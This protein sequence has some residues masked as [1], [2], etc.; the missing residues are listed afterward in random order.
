M[1]KFFASAF[2]LSATLALVAGLVFA[3]VGTASAPAGVS[4][5]I[6]EVDVALQID[7]YTYSPLLPG[8]SVKTAN[9][10][11]YNATGIPVYITGGSISGI[12]V[13]SN[14]GCEPFI[15]G[16]VTVTDNNWINNNSYG[17]GWD[18]YL[19]LTSN[20]HQDCQTLGVNYTINVDV[21]T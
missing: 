17:G 3:W 19:A 8:I 18:S 11:V 21:T 4:S 20:T 5:V 2:A 10:R 12:D 9:G 16:S 14:G 1:R 6:G 7:N 15:S 13:P